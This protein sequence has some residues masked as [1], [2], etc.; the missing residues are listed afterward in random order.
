MFN[1]EKLSNKLTSLTP[2]NKFLVAY[3]GGMDSH[4]LLHSVKQLNLDIR[5][6]HVHHGL[7]KN[8]DLWVEHCRKICTD[9]NIEYIV[10]YIKIP[11]GKHSPEAMARDLRYQEFAKLLGEDECLLTAHHADDQAETLLLQLF[12]GSGTKGLAAMPERKG[13]MH[14]ALLRPL[15]EFSRAELNE[16]AEQN[17]LNWIEDESNENIGLDRNFVRHKLMPIIK[18][19][20]PSI[21]RTAARVTEHFAEASELLTVLAEQ[22]YLNVQGAKADTLS[23]TKL[24]KLSD[25]RQSNVIRYWLHKLDLPT[26]NSIQLKHIKKDVLYCR[27]DAQPLVHWPGAE[28]RKFRDDLYAISRP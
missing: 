16:Y 22:D 19:K 14:G 15:L 12:R 20:Y 5:A 18:E 26:P 6:V 3:S 28:V 13:F 23:I 25:A 21:L 10:K 1:P 27:N 4:V 8:A 9:L 24:K 7:S 2:N 17:N 11:L